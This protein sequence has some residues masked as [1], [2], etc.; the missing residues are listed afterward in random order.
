MKMFCTDLRNHAMKI[1]N[2]EKKEMIPLT[3]VE[4]EFTLKNL[5]ELLI[6]FVI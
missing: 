4:S 5:E 6:V 2:Y 3:D 1:V